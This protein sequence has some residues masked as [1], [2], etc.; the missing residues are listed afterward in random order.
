MKRGAYSYW[1]KDQIEAVPE[2]VKTED[3]AEVLVR[4]PSVLEQ[5]D[6]RIYFYAEINR[7]NIL[8]LN[9]SLR[10]L[11]NDLITTSNL[12]EFNMYPPIILHINTYGGNLFDGL[13]G[14]DEIINCKVEVRTIVDGCC[15]SSGTFLSVAG[16]QRFINRH[17]FMLIHQLSSFFW[18]PYSEFQDEKKNLDR[19]MDMIKDVY[20][21]FTKVPEETIDEILKHDLWFDAKTCLEYGL[22][23][24]IL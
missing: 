2:E 8:R 13:A 19:L 5:V 7:Q 17:A 21:E 18:G 4:E 16:K 15:A 22:V 20:K 9:K 10:R 3:K 6:N 11:S 24:K 12:Q 14:L 1:G 23:D